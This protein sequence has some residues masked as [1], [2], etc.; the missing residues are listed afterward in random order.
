MPYV[1]PLELEAGIGLIYLS[2][3]LIGSV[4]SRRSLARS[5]TIENSRHAE[6]RLLKGIRWVLAV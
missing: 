4:P 5:L 1:A 6:A 3:Y 2:I